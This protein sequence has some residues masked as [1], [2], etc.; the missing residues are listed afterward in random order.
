MSGSERQRSLCAAVCR[1]SFSDH[2]EACIEKRSCFPAVCFLRNQKRGR[3]KKPV[4]LNFLGFR[5][6]VCSHTITAASPFPSCPAP[7]P[8]EKGGVGMWCQF[9]AQELEPCDPAAGGFA[10]R[11]ASVR[12]AW[13]VL[14][15]GAGAHRWELGGV[16]VLRAAPGQPHH[17][18]LSRREMAAPA[19]Q[20]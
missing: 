3:G 8:S 5:T 14:L 15:E 20:T 4:K 12:G 16:T 6:R 10:P 7:V 9:L 19:S 2:T 18:S 17:V 13:E 1:S 11:A